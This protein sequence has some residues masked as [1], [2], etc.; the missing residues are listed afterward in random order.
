MYS[1]DANIFIYAATKSSPF[2]KQA[3]AF[4]TEKFS[5]SEPCF[6]CWETLHAFIRIVTNPSIFSKPMTFSTAFKYIEE[7]LNLPQV[8]FL[9]ASR[10]SFRIMKSYE[11]IMPLRGNL[12][13]DAVIASQLEAAGIKIIYTN[14]RDY[15]KFPALK[16]KS[17][18]P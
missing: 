4:I 9:T 1:I 7:I 14:D 3:E 8:D 11:K 16:P 10:D 5:D 17:P 13:S 18:F 12:I 6:L 2:Q 15:F